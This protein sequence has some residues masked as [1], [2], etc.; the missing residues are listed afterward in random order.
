MAHNFFSKRLK[1]LTVSRMKSEDSIKT[2][3]ELGKLKPNKNLNNIKLEK[4]TDNFKE[5]EKIIINKIK[6][7][8]INTEDNDMNKYYRNN[9]RLTTD[10]NQNIEELNL[11]QNPLGIREK[12]NNG[13]YRLNLDKISNNVNCFDNDNDVK[14]KNNNYY[15][16]E[17]NKNKDRSIMVDNKLRKDKEVIINKNN[18]LKD[19]KINKKN[20]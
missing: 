13:T 6:N 7:M 18:N 8:R 14:N 15:T 2:V 5:K 16:I 19:S 9:R 11:K 3:S 4:K 17:I 12:K 1:S 10:I 20:R